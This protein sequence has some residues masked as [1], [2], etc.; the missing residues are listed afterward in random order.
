MK[1]IS[2]G[3]RS[4]PKRRAARGGHNPARYAG[5]RH[6]A[7]AAEERGERE[8]A[9]HTREQAVT[10]RESHQ[11][12]DAAVPAEHGQ[13]VTKQSDDAR[14]REQALR[15]RA[16]AEAAWVDRERLIEQMREAN[17]R[18]VVAT[19]RADELTEIAVAASVAAADSATF[20]AEA[21]R[22]AEATATQLL[23]ADDALRASES[24]ARAS[25][26]AKDDFLAMLGHELRNP[27]APIL[28]AL[29]LIGLDAA[30][31]HKREHTI[32]ERQVNQLVGL[33]DDLLDVSRIRSGKI[34]LH[35]EPIEL[36]EVVSRAAEMAGPLIESRHH[37]LTDTVPPRG[38]AIEGDLLRLTQ[39]IGNLLTNAA[40][41]TPPG[42]MIAVTSEHDGPNVVLRVRDNGIGISKDMIPHVFDLFAQ[43]HQ[44]T[45]RPAGG[46]GL[47]LAIVRSLVE[48]HG[49]TVTASS[50]GLGHGSEF[51][52]EL[53]A[54]PRADSAPDDGAPDDGASA[55]DARGQLAKI[56][57]VDDNHLAADLTGAALTKLGHDVRVAHDPA[58][59]L[60]SVES[61]VPEL[62]LLDIGLPGMDGYALAKRLRA[63]VSPREVRFIAISGYGLAA[64]R[65]RSADA[66]FDE[67][68]VKPVDLATLQRSI[69]RS[70]SLRGAR[71]ANG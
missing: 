11:R 29:D 67:H 35:R 15:A 53:P 57:V 63:A 24:E 68:L 25:N 10:R 33:V 32:I 47:G 45:D 64:D 20:E 48:L 44:T 49:G 59:A 38:L 21:R 22:R 69:A 31:A 30:D 6:R 8:R 34:D 60:S 61:F 37:T 66:G 70:R 39:A 3:E 4:V 9:A 43:E 19:L 71:G 51:V 5:S 12:T 26:R 28:L 62:V 23:A 50:D 56:L 14:L 54:A 1:R 52:V 27:L 40:K 41:Y 7:R 17:E 65:Q 2:S 58:S 18:L 13:T 42:G 36:A 16:E 55:D 46:L